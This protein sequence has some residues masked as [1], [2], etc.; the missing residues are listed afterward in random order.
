[1]TVLKI[2]SHTTGAAGPSSDAQQGR[3]GAVSP[4]RQRM[5]RDMKLAGLT[6]NTQQCYLRAVVALQRH[7]DTCPDKLTEEQ[8][9]QYV[10]WL[11]D[12]KGVPKSTCQPHWHGIKFFY[13][14]TL[15]VDWPLF[16][17]KKVRQ[18][19]RQ[20]AANLPLRPPTDDAAVD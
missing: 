6:L 19:N 16:T 3:G 2:A 9:Y 8:V 11:R 7:T 13:F 12:A 10:L 17:R 4:L 18:L 5:I 1:M 20:D 14:R 15:G